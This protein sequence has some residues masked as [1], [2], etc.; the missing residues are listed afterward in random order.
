MKKRLPAP[1]LCLWIVLIFFL[2]CDHNSAEVPVDPYRDAVEDALFSD[3][4]EIC[5]CLV[6]ITHDNDDLSWSG[7]MVLV[8]TFTSFPESFPEGETIQTWWGDTWV[9]TVPELK[10]F[11]EEIRLSV[12]DP[13][14]RVEQV[15]GLPKNS[16]KEW[17]AELWV[18]P[19]DLFR[20]CPDSEITDSACEL[21][22]PHSATAEYMDWFN[23]Q[24]IASYF[25][26][27][28]YPWTRL[29]YTYDWGNPNDE[30][31]LSE[32]IIKQD[33]EVLVERLESFEQYLDVG[34]HLNY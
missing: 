28:T 33:A 13:M 2:G 10:E 34:S 5:D 11:Y 12:D 8:V 17:F 16:A 14:L 24:I 19:R 27:P 23:D 9:T 25:Q 15:L 31:G 1:L 18:H 6:A 29:G 3:E 32:F 22:F 20:P 26:E 21:T 30:I 7:G 4:D